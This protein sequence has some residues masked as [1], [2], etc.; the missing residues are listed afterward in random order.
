MA[1]SGN[2]LVKESCSYSFSSL[3]IVTQGQQPQITRCW[4]HNWQD[5]LEAPLVPAVSS[6]CD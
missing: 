5:V 2:D 6:F 3:V 4:V 1:H